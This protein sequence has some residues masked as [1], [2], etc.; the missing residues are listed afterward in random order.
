M[1][2][3]NKL[4]L[5]AVLLLLFLF[6]VS[7]YGQNPVSWSLSSS[8]K[9][10]KAGEKFNV[11]L[12]G[13]V[14]SGWYIYS[15]TQGAGGPYPTRV[16]VAAPFALAGGVKGPAPK[17]QMDANFGI[18]T[19]KYLG[20]ANLTVPVS[21]PATTA[22]GAQTLEVSVRFQTC[23]DEVC[24]P[25]KTVKVSAP[26]EIA[27]ADANALNSPSPTP[28]V[29]PTPTPKNANVNANTNVNANL[30]ANANVNANTNINSNVTPDIAPLAEKSNS[31][32]NSTASLST[33]NNNP[34][35]PTNFDNGGFSQDMPLWSFLWAAFIAGALSLLTPCVFPMIPITVSYF[36]NHA[37][38]SRRTATINAF[39]FALGIIFTFT[40]LGVLLAVLFGAAG[41]NQ[42]AANPYVNIFIGGLF[43]AFAM[44]LFGAFNLGL[45][46]TVLTKIDSFARGKESSQF[47][48][49]LLM[50]L[51][52]SMTSFTCTTPLVGGLLV[53]ATQ[54][55]WLY[56]ILGMLA[57]SSVF[58]LPFFI[59][60]LAPQLV[61]QLPKSGGWLN[62]VKVV[63]GFL[64]I[65]AAMKFISNVD[66]VWG[67]GIFTREVVLATWV[68][69]SLLITL[70]LLGIFQ[71]SHDMK[72]ERLGAVRVMVSLV[73]LSVSFYLLTGLFG[74]T[75]GEIES[76][77][78]PRIENMTTG[79]TVAGNNN[80]PKT[81][82]WITNDYNAALAR[83]K[84]E[85]KAV[86][87]DFTGYTCTNCRWMEANMFPKPKV[88]EELNK[89]VRVRLYTDGEGEP[90]EG[91]Q[92]M[93][94]EKFST[95]ALPLYA[96][97]DANGNTLATFPGLTRD[98]NV[99]VKFLQAGQEK[100][101]A[102]TARA[103]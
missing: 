47:I 65:A 24:L 13:T 48:G 5:S 49:L 4:R 57:F 61:A 87:I 15:V 103:N 63:M 60:A 18:E 3:F 75:L 26:I 101:S 23:N 95:V 22:P 17:R 29:S 46:P 73:F 85:N 88:A 91:F 1:N 80:A 99:F 32:T 89:Y 59:L 64:E 7:I 40:I 42:F 68:A 2:S 14:Q 10:A 12:S 79:S 25:P 54:G 43:I 97:V 69:V 38:G 76:F 52:F 37:G 77:L 16:T 41:I 35:A 102:L 100:L 81:E 11:Q 74:K 96:V 58:A 27:A 31:E 21:V 71:L 8:K 78:P 20:G 66:L 83:A 45:P 56:P 50:G 98:E 70:Y 67:W 62:S 34:T 94:E 44:S 28:T 53:L 33:Q 55:S 82:D 6:G 36:T 19:E 39:V 72:A 90:Y 93:Q 30:N 84:A 92:K 86:F 51:V 9:T